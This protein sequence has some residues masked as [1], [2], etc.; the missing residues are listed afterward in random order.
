[1]KER[2]NVQNES[3]TDKYLG[4]PSDVGRAKNGA[5]KYLRDRVWKRIQGWMEILLSA[6][7]KEVLIKAV[8]Q[9]IPTYSMS[10]FK[11]PR[12][13]CESINSLIRN[14]WW[15]S[16]DGKRKTCW[17]S[18]AEMTTPKYAGG[19]GF[20]D[21]ELFN[22][23]LLARQAWRILQNPE[24][25]SARILKAV[26]YPSCDFLK[27]EVGSHPSQI[28]RALV[29]GRDTLKVGLIRRIGTGESAHAWHDNWLPRDTSMRPIACL[30]IDPPECVADFIDEMQACWKVEQLR[31]CFLPMDIEVIRGIP[32]STRRHNDFWSWQFE[33]SGM[34][35][36]R[37]TYKMLLNTKI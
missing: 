36:V 29:E 13:L 21:I 28:W 3:L 5:F 31:E 4:M 2:L 25:P 26:Y 18:W 34:F 1:M 32:L 6:G 20:R 12:G 27:A 17:V 33:R 37:S 10:C 24:T 19:L 14:F 16:R 9:A 22:L 23:A 35:S 30:K 7:G 8:A 15:G 11:L